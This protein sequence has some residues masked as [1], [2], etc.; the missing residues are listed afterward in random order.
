MRSR[1]DP[2][3]EAVQHMQPLRRTKMPS[4]ARRFASGL[5]LGGRRGEAGEAGCNA[6]AAGS[7]QGAREEGMVD[8]NGANLVLDDRNPVGEVRG[9]QDA[10]QEGG[11]AGAEKAWSRR[12]QAGLRRAARGSSGSA[13]RGCCPGRVPVMT[14]MGVEPAVAR[15]RWRA[16]WAMRWSLRNWSPQ[17]MRLAT[18][19]DPAR[20]RATAK[21]ADAE[22][23][24]ENNGP[25]A[26]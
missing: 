14:V 26:P 18:K 4:S 21:R 20:K 11:L 17:A 6:P 3:P 24:A 7:R 13:E 1:S 9:G 23:I 15:A 10:V 19:R 25:I 22:G 8:G 2:E 12:R 5:S 16:C